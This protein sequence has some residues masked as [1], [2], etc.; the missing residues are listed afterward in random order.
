[1]EGHADFEWSVMSCRI[2]GRVRGRPVAGQ[3][4]TKVDH[5]ASAPGAPVDPMPREPRIA[6]AVMPRFGRHRGSG[7]ARAARMW[8]SLAVR[9]ALARKPEWRMGR[10]PWGRTCSRKR[11]VNLAASGGIALP[12]W[13]G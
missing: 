13:G 9:Q 8:A 6:L 11:R 1:M 5:A 12:F 2:G 7:A 3:R 4:K 10:K